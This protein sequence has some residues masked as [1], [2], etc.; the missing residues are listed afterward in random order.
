MASL[1]ELLNN[2]NN[3]FVNIQLTNE[4]KLALFE[5]GTPSN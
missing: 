2:Y 4:Q 1:L 3:K 5:N